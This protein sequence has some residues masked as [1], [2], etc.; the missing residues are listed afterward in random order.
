MYDFDADEQPNVFAAKAGLY[1]GELVSPS[2]G[3]GVRG[4][5]TP[6]KSLKIETQFGAFWQEIDGSPVFHLCELKHCHNA[7]QWY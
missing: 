2:P 4:F 1:P 3:M 5:Y 7:R 6:G